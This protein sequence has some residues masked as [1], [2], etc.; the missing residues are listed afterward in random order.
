MYVQRR[1][2]RDTSRCFVGR[3]QTGTRGTCAVAAQKGH[4]E[5]LQWAHTNGCPWD[6][7]TCRLAAM[8]GHLEV[9]LWLRA[10]DCPWNKQQ[11]ML[12]ATEGQHLDVMAW[13]RRCDAHAIVA[14]RDTRSSHGETRKRERRVERH[15][16]KQETFKTGHAGRTTRFR[17]GAAFFVI[18]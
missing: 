18:E 6:K 5:V 13:L 15:V 1:R 11:C 10:N 3:A 16:Q 14:R 8:G 12:F 9:L 7:E 2:R 17:K 4:L